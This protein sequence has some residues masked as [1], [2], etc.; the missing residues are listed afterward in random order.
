MTARI[1][2]LATGATYVVQSAGECRDQTDRS[3]YLALESLPGER[4][5]QMGMI[6]VERIS[7]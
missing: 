3:A 6:C 7:P 5:V 1:T 2:D 4:V